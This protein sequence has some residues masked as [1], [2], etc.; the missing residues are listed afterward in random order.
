VIA[1]K[2]ERHRNKRDPGCSVIGSQVEA[3]IDF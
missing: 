2:I 3:A 1:V